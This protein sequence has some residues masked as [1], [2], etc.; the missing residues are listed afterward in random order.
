MTAAST[1]GIMFVKFVFAGLFKMFL[2]E[3]GVGYSLLGI[4]KL[5]VFGGTASL[6]STLLSPVES[7]EI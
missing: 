5:R 6:K 7:N 3:L 1:F 4:H 2:I